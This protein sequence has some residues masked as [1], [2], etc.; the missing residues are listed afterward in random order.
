MAA[1]TATHE[2]TNQPPP[3][4]DADVLGD[5]RVLVAAVERWA[6][7]A[8]Q[9]ERA[10][11]AALGIRAGGAVAQGWGEAA[12]VHPPTLHTHDRYGHRIDEVEYTPAYHQLMDTAVGS[13]L[14]AAPW[15]SGEPGAHVLRAAGFYLWS[16]VDAGHG[17]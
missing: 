8:S 10:Q 13:G 7:G 3:L 14:H 6:G 12:N 17:C 4:L 11:L 2:V 16:Q 1:M 15:V 5:D 9:A